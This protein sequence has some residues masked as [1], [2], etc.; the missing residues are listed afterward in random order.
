MKGRKIDIHFTIFCEITLL[1]F[2]FLFVWW[3]DI[4]L[5][6]FVLT[7]VFGCY[8]FTFLYE[9]LLGKLVIILRWIFFLNVCT[10]ML[11]VIVKILNCLLYS[12]ICKNLDTDLLLS[13]VNLET[14]FF[15]Y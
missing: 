12:L 7:D 15:I 8:T 13:F 4:N 11:F 14:D 1:Y 5:N 3:M 6:D 10:F 2:Y 9:F